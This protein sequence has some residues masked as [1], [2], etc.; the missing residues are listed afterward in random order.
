M[1]R[2]EVVFSIGYI[3]SLRGP[4]FDHVNLHELFL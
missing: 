2:E 3:P 1:K 4:R